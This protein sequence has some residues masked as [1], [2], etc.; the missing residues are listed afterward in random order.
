MTDARGAVRPTVFGSVP[1]ETASEEAAACATK[2]LSST[3]SRA[4][5]PV[6]ALLAEAVAL[7]PSLTFAHSLRGMLRVAAFDCARS[8]PS[9]AR[10][11]APPPRPRPPPPPTRPPSNAP[12]RLRRGIRR[13]SPRSPLRKRPRC[14]APRPCLRRRKDRRALSSVRPTF[15]PCGLPTTPARP[16]R[17]RRPDGPRSAHAHFKYD[18]TPGM[19]QLLAL[20]AEV[21][22]RRGVT[23]R[24]RRWARALGLDPHEAGAALAVA[25]AMEAGA[26][27]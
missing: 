12:P 19:A 8:P 25:A 16:R 18:G 20:Q 13:R 22:P 9:A 6:P 1:P 10:R 5:A 4:R 21:L 7:D 23:S 3:A 2:R 27:P 26:V 17:R 14:G 24:P 11:C 15:C